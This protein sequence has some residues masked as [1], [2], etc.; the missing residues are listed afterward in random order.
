[1]IYVAHRQAM[2]ERRTK[3]KDEVDR[4][5][6]NKLIRTFCTNRLIL[7]VWR[8]MGRNRMCVVHSEVRPGSVGYVV[9][10]IATQTRA[11]ENDL[12]LVG[13]DSIWM[14]NT[15]VPEQDRLEVLILVQIVVVV[16][17]SEARVGLWGLSSWRRPWL[18]AAAHEDEDLWGGRTISRLITS[19][20]LLISANHIRRKWFV[21]FCDQKYWRSKRRKQKIKRNKRRIIHRSRRACMIF[22]WAFVAAQIWYNTNGEFYFYSHSQ[23]HSWT[24]NSKWRRPP[25]NFPYVHAVLDNRRRHRRRHERRF[26]FNWRW[27]TFLRL[28]SKLLLCAR[29]SCT[30]HRACDRHRRCR[31]RGCSSTYPLSIPKNEP[32]AI[33]RF[34]LAFVCIHNPHDIFTINSLCL[35]HIAQCNHDRTISIQFYSFFFCYFF[36]CFFVDVLHDRFCFA[37]S[38]RRS[39]LFVVFFCC[40]CFLSDSHWHSRE[41]RVSSPLL[42]PPVLHRRMCEPDGTKKSRL[43]QRSLCSR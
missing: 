14:Y 40:C 5:F 42:H 29:T 25:W 3:N 1:M 23:P 13:L 27:I 6:R 31:R 10:L 39:R 4:Q 26:T 17:C 8:L 35:V 43:A 18:V 9:Q 33:G 11:N 24:N 41:R 16:G 15:M 28:Y 32:L 21:N 36:L 37:H 34:S 12:W 7:P 38:R 20:W 30:D 2:E 19:L 22:F